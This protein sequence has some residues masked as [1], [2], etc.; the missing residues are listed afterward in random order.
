MTSIVALRLPRS[1]VERLEREARGLGMGL[2]EYV[3]ELLLHDLDPPERVRE[4][5]EAARLLLQRAREELEKG[6][7]R[8]AAEKAWG[9]AA[10]AVKA[11]AAWRDGRRLASHGELWEYKRRLEKE[12]GEWVHD[13]W[14]NATGMHVCFYEGWC[15]REDVEKALERIGRLVGEIGKRVGAR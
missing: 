8:Q 3:L 13:A 1:V 14:M 11:Y 7:V 12:L 6:D 4:Y 9:A 2:E 15:T 10:L 5:I